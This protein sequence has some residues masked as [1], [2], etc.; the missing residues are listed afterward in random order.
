MAVL[1]PGSVEEEEAG[2][3]GDAKAHAEF[4][5]TLAEQAWCPKAMAVVKAARKDGCVCA[6]LV[7]R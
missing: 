2:Q 4:R 1:L 3:G 7:P 5:C 6:S